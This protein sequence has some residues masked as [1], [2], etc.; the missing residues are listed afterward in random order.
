ML[1]SLA[2]DLG[3]S[4]PAAGQLVSLGGLVMALGA[5]L[6]AALTSRIERRTVLIAALGFYF[7]GGLACAIAPN[8]AVLL[9]IRAA[10]MMG[11]AVF[12]PQAAATVAVLVAPEQRT[13]A[14]TTVFL[15]W[16]IS[17][18]VAMPL[19]NWIATHL[20]WRYGFVLVALMAAVG[21]LGL[22][23]VIPRAV[24]V[25]TLDLK[26]WGDV[27][28]NRSLLLMLGVTLASGTGQFIVLSYIAPYLAQGI[29][30]STFTF[31]VLMGTNGLFG[32]LGS[33]WMT[34]TIGR[35]GIEKTV[36]SALLVLALGLMLWAL[37]AL[38][39]HAG[40]P[41][42]AS[43]VLL[44]LSSMCWGAGSFASNGAQQARLSSTAP[45]LTSASVALNSSGM[46]TGQA[47]GAAI[48]GLM[49]AAFGLDS[50]GIV[51]MVLG[52]LALGLSALA[53][54]SLKSQRAA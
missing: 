40:I 25:P 26:A 27:L 10:M 5:P 30:A 19:A 44:L 23:R 34:R 46:Y 43:F 33:L 51:S 54:R 12:S 15:G 48:G 24:H 7:V 37:E 6:A 21:M 17:A 52:A 39:R 3:V 49:I 1:N 53:A 22:W 47:L 4:I 41:R 13:R 8:L 18:V 45:A 36:R 29:D 9:P 11:P 28:R 16:S 38:L 20:G 50:L 32:L 42:S 35:R 14:I 31:A 2:Q